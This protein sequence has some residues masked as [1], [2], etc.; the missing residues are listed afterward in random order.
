MDRF[1]F[2]LMG[3]RLLT[4]ARGA[5]SI[6]IAEWILAVML[7]FEKRLPE[8]WLDDAPEHW[9]RGNLGATA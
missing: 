2:E 1:P 3:D 8:V 6:P 5:S 7:A 9:S 4:C